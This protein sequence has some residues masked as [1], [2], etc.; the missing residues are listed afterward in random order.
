VA[1]GTERKLECYGFS[2]VNSQGQMQIPANARKALDL[3]N[4]TS[5][6]VFADRETRQL[7]VTIKPLDD[8]LLDLATRTATEQV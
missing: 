5:L 2:K 6:M 3:E 8:E 4:G 7:V 1:K